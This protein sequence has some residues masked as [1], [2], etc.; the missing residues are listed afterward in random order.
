VPRPSWIEHVVAVAVGCLALGLALGLVLA[1]T[2]PSLARFSAGL[3]GHGGR[4]PGPHA[5]RM[6]VAAR[7]SWVATWAA[8]PEAADDGAPEHGFHDQTI[9]DVIYTSAGGTAVRVKISNLF[10][11]RPLDVG[12]ASVG[13]VLDGAGLLSAATRPLAFGDSRK[14]S[15]TIPAGGS[16]TSDA[17]AYE[18]PPLTDLAVSLYLP[19]ATGPATWHSLAQQDSYVAHGD[20][21]LSG[22]AMP[23]GLTEHSWYFLTEVDVRSVAAPGTVVAFGDSITDGLGSRSGSDDRW[24]N[25]L[26]RRLEAAYEDRAPGV[27]DEGISGNR[28]L[29]GCTGPSALDRFTRDAL[30]VSGVRAVILLEGI[31]DIGYASRPPGHC[32]KAAGRDVTAAEIE[33]GYQR[34]IALGHARGVAV[35]LGTL[36]PAAGLTRSGQEMREAV[37]R[38]ILSSYAAHICDGVI[39][40]AGAIA[41]PDDPVYFSPADNSGDDLHPDDL[42]YSQMASAVPL[43]WLK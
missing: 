29:S 3:I 8:S 10:G 40:F 27:V 31:N 32:A 20:H 7:S 15:V 35:Y 28:V 14:G 17:V 23:Y 16:V 34:L 24:P 33:G 1:A 22:R 36:T 5:V 21:A 18:V 42:G 11:T 39:D 13:T 26:A 41:D 2:G 4:A 38:W 12:A 37:N 43:A 9:R 25:F 6:T 19:R 30:G